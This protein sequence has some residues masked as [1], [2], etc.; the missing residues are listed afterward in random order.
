MRDKCNNGS[1]GSD[2]GSE[3]QL[4]SWHIEKGE[5]KEEDNISWILKCQIIPKEFKG[6]YWCRFQ[7]FLTLWLCKRHSPSLEK[8]FVM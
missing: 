8:V 7:A 3:Q 1:S 6:D 5:K 2:N 4:A